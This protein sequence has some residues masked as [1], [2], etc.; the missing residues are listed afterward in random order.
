L[1]WEPAWH[2][3]GSES[4]QAKQQG[5][6]LQCKCFHSAEQKL[7]ILFCK[8]WTLLVNLDLHLGGEAG[9]QRDTATPACRGWTMPL[10]TQPT[11]RLSPR[12]Y[13]REMYQQRTIPGV[14]FSCIPHMSRMCNHDPELLPHDYNQ[15]RIHPDIGGLQS[16]QR[17]A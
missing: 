17:F 5:Y 2:C 7:C 3:L 12:W 1:I 6:C 8:G 4:G 11:T 9:R 10:P 14:A 15:I 16:C 13:P